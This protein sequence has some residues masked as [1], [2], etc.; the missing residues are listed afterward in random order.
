[1]E[2]FIKF[3]YRYSFNKSGTY[4]VRVLGEDNYGHQIV[5]SVQ[6]IITIENDIP[7]VPIIEGNNSGKSGIRITYYFKSIDKNEHRI[8]YIVDWDDGSRNNTKLNNSGEHV[9]LIHIWKNEGSYEIKAKAIDEFEAESDWATLEINIPKTK[10]LNDIL[11][12]NILNNHPLVLLIL[13]QL[14]N[15]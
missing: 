8:G 6:I 5:F 13:K 4:E 7:S 3:I 2:A 12:L 14:L 1:L 9:Q 10:K 11:I 15:L